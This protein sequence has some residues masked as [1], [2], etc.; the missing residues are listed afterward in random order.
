MDGDGMSTQQKGTLAAFIEAYKASRNASQAEEESGVT[1]QRSYPPAGFYVYALV[2]PANQE[3]FYVGKGIGGRILKH[4]ER[5]KRG[6]LQN[7][8]KV[9]RIQKIFEAGYEVERRILFCSEDEGV[10]LSVEENI[11]HELAGMGLTNIIGGVSVQC[12][13][14]RRWADSIRTRLDSFRAGLNEM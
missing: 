11:I 9:K 12:P 13:K 5:T 7:K 14:V 8:A 10:V 2:D 6:V 4:Q 3:I 1:L